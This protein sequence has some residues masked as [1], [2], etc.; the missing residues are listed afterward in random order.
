MYPQRSQLE[1]NRIPTIITVDGGGQSRGIGGNG[2]DVA[3]NGGSI[4]SPNGKC[5]DGRNK[6]E[7]IHG[8]NHLEDVLE[9]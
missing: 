2:G 4:S 7:D 3:E 5:R 6:E 1:W 9:G 8:G